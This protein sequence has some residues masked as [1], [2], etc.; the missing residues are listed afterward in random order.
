MEG[1]IDEF[2]AV[3]SAGYGYG[4]GWSCGC[5]YRQNYGYG[6]S[7]NCGDGSD[8][9]SGRGYG[10]GTGHGHGYDDTSGDGSGACFRYRPGYSIDAPDGC[11][12]GDGYGDSIKSINGHDVYFIDNVRTVIE[13]VH[14]NYAVG[15]ILENNVNLVPCYIAKG[16]GYFAH[17]ETLRAAHDALKAKIEGNKPIEERIADFMDEFPDIDAKVDAARLYNWH[18][19]LTGSCEM[20]RRAFC[21][22]HG[23]DYKHGKY[24]VREFIGICKD[25]YGSETIKML[26]DKLNLT[27]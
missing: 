10:Y 2:L 26:S 4:C 24:S 3:P 16:E 8:K 27:L 19:A 25:A 20:G 1:V 13:H 7:D 21:E 22:E 18:H 6:N 17:G 5:G 23:I 12:H 15:Y 9:G 11:G 14:G